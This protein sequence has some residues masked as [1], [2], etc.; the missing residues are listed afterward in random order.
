MKCV[1]STLLCSCGGI[2]RL[3]GLELTHHRHVLGFKSTHRL[4]VLSLNS[5]SFFKLVVERRQTTFHFLK[6][7]LDCGSQVFPRRV[8]LQQCVCLRIQGCLLLMKLAN[9]PI[10]SSDGSRIFSL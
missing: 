8:Q 3:K 5:L 10:E 9:L 2:Q 4:L 7:L 6:A 1:G